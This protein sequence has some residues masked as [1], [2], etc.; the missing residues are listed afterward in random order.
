M[1][2]RR[3]NQISYIPFNSQTCTENPVS[4]GCAVCSCAV[5]ELVERTDSCVLCVELVERTDS[6]VLCVE[7]AG[8]TDSCVLCVELA[9]R[10]D[11]CAVCRTG[12]KD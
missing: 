4:V 6:C 8:R 11:S 7:L 9:G 5:V 1:V 12:R 10:T 3:K 2:H